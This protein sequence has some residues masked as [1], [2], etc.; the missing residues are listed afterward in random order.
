MEVIRRLPGCTALGLRCEHRWQVNEYD[1][2]LVARGNIVTLG[3]VQDPGNNEPSQGGGSKPVPNKHRLRNMNSLLKNS[4]KVLIGF[5]PAFATFALTKDWWL[6]AYGGAFIWFGITGLRNVLQS[7]LG[8]GGLRRSSLLRWNDLISWQRT[9]DSLLFT[10]F[11]VPLLDYLTKTLILDQGL[12]ITTTT[13][14]VWL[15]SLMALANGIYLSSHNILRGLPKGAVVGNFFRSILS[16]PLA[17]GFN[18]LLTG[19]LTHMGIVPAAP[20]L[21]KWAAIISKT[22]SDIVAGIIEGTADRFQNIE[23]RRNALAHK[24]KQILD[25]YAEI[26]ILLPEARAME[27]LQSPEKWKGKISAD[28]RDM[29]KRMF[30]HALDLLYFWM[31]QPRARIALRTLIK[32]LS[33]EERHILLQAQTVLR[34]DRPISQ[35]FVDGILGKGFAK[36]LAFY[37]SQSPVYLAAVEKLLAAEKENPET[38]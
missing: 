2:H 15:Y 18:T 12:S 28:V 3:G 26:E 1:T 8:G 25:T 7:V 14:P 36:P 34:Q 4:L 22:A 29:A 13:H 21:Q 19:V 27:Y 6:L 24:I 32:T 35:M 30:V 23:L 33:A 9:T 11:S 10:G 16:I 5:G 37:L 20:I 17:I 38:V 31:Y